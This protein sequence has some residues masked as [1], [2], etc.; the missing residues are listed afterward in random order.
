M[1]FFQKISKGNWSILVVLLLLIG[2]NILASQWHSRI[3]LTREKRF[4]LTEATQSLLKKIEG[5]ITIDVVL[6]GNY[7]SGFKQLASGTE[8][9]L[10]TFKE[11]AGNKI[12]YHLVAPEET[13]GSTGVTYADTA[14]ALGIKSINL[15]SQLKDGQQQQTVFPVAFITHDN[16]FFPVELY[17]GKTPLINNQELASAEALLEYQLANA[18]FH[19]T[20]QKKPIIGYATG[21]GEPTDMSVYDM[22]EN[23]LQKEYQLQL[24]NIANQPFINPSCE[25]LLLVK[26]S[27]PF[28][29]DQKLKIDQYIMHGG[30][31]MFF[32]DRL[33]AEMDSLQI[34]NEVIAYDRE[35]NLNDLL[36]RYGVRINANLLMDLQC[37]YLPFDV[38]GNGQFDFLPWNYF[39]VIESAENHPINKGLGFVAGKFVN[40]IDTVEAEGITK[41]IL[42]HS[43]VNARTIATPALISGRENVTAPEDNKYQTA[44]I[45]VAVLLEGDFRSLYANRLTQAMQDSLAGI[46]MDFIP[47]SYKS[48]KIIVV[49]DGDIV[50]NPV[51]KGNQPLE[52]GMNPFTVGSQREFPFANRDF[53][54]N[55]VEYMI[56]NNG[57]SLAK[58]KDFKVHLLDSKRVREEK[59]FWILTNFFI[60]I[61][62]VLLFAFVFQFIRKKRY[63]K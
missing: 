15:T 8:D 44:N 41:T 14:L 3:D 18:I 43:S 62:F 51:V 29:D 2:I 55:A 57:L 30:K 31:V 54:T 19:I 58:S 16:Q 23:T 61:L 39:P 26:P 37:D 48:S 59:N 50:L 46:K 12:Q 1:N 35:L 28:T 21:N 38:S 10:R 17:K 13:I 7:P 60:P 22:A 53:L 25:L 4:T 49:S 9:L 47:Q 45:P 63:E 20:Q 33:N 24:I 36:F 40:S 11:I 42:L 6:K 27:V 52:M 56:N 5:T 34:K 32:I